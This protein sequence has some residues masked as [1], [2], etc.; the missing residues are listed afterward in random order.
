MEKLEKVCA[1]FAQG[2]GNSIRP[3]LSENAKWTIV[4]DRAVVGKGAVCDFC[5]ELTEK[6]FPEFKNSRVISAGNFIIVEGSESGLQK[7]SNQGL[8][9]CDVFEV[10]DNT[11]VEIVSYAVS[12]SKAS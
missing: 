5:D 6:G 1:A 4:G 3:H 11:V 9:Y 8:K 2:D 12:P 7:E 10:K